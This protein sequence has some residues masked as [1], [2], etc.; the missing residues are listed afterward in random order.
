MKQHQN[1]IR[2]QTKAHWMPPVNVDAVVELVATGALSTASAGKIL[3]RIRDEDGKRH[4]TQTS[5]EHAI[6]TQN[7]RSRQQASDSIKYHSTKKGKRVLVD[8]KSSSGIRVVMRCASSLSAGKSTVS[9]CNCKYRV[10][11]RKSKTKGVAPVQSIDQYVMSRDGDCSREF[12][13]HSSPHSVVNEDSRQ[14]AKVLIF[15]FS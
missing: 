7:W 14:H 4:F 15:T 6:L 8:R 2:S 12:G 9:K 13:G 5:E 1:Q 3:R 11:L 10:V